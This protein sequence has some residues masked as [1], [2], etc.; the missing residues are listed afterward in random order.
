MP[1]RADLAL[2]ARGLFASRAKAR[3]AIEAGLVRLDGA[4]VR[5]P[6]E[7]VADAAQLDAEAPY[8]WVSRGGVKLAAALDIFGIDPAGKQALDI[9]AS[10]GGFA[11]VLLSRG[12]AHVTCVDV[13][14]GQLHEKIAR[15]PRV[16]ALEKFDARKLTLAD[17]PGAPQIVV[18]D[19]SFIS[20]T[21]VLPPVL[22]LA[23][24]G[25]TAALLVKPQFE[26]GP[27][28]VKKG[29]VRDARVHAEVCDKIKALVVDLGWRVL[30]VTPSPISGGDGNIE[31]L[32][33][34]RRA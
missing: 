5:K 24:P 2:V 28:H 16:T 6:S 7:P 13:G 10:T 20:L 27:K 1:K 15:D 31:F 8:P 26:A 23:E 12:A 9:G 33:G 14:T 21:L 11:D 17:L 19:V 22:A 32:L 4:L 34:A 18:C 29:F 3:E 30:G 25:A